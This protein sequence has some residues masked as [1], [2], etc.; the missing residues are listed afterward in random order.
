MSV[1]RHLETDSLSNQDLSAALAIGAYTADADRMIVC[2]VSLDQVAGNGDYM[3]YL[4]RRINGAGS[5]YVMLPKTTCSAAS[6]ETAIAMQS[7]PVTVRSGD[8]VTVYVLGLAGDTVTPDTVVRWYEMAALRPA[9]ADRTALIDSNGRVE[10]AGTLNAL[11]D[12]NDLDAAGVLAAVYEGSETVQELL[13]LMRAV[14]VGKSSGGGAVYRD[15]ADSK[16][17]V[18][19]T[20]DGS[21]NRTAVTVDAT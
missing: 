9:T 7:G 4:T 1:N 13:R 18:T 10:I 8:V 11:D 12:L 14:L 3:I 2:D 6:G 19:A 5:S 17:R 21:G 16:A 20:L 15:A